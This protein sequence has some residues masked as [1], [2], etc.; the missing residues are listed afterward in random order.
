MNDQ[1]VSFS[2]RDGVA[3][4]TLCCPQQAN[5]IGVEM[6]RQLYEAAV[7]CDCDEVR[8]VL[9]QAEG[10]IFCAGGDVKA[11]GAA[12]DALPDLLAEILAPMHA[13]IARF[14]QMNAPLIVA[15][16]GPA[17]GGG[18]GLACAGDLVLAADTAKFAIAYT[19]IGLTPDVSSTYFVP[20]RIGLARTKSMLLCN[21]VLDAATALEWGLVDRVVAAADLGSEAAKLAR[22]FASGP[23]S[24]FGA[25]KRLLLATLT[26]DLQTQLDLEAR[27]ICEMGATDD[28]KEGIRA[29]LEKRPA[30]F[31][32]S[33]K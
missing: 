28:G 2:L 12:G 11:F 20:R 24:A 10:P 32:R 29:F 4:V 5:S 31:G 9:L 33:P 22:E 19:R 8:A 25:V 17:A 15:V 7:R 23:T 16:G 18:L 27:T 13:A 26:N 14:S 1:R 3:T 6:S 21:P 30:R